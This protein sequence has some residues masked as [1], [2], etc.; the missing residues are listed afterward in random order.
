MGEARGSA[1][2]H[3]GV[4]GSVGESGL[5]GRVSAGKSREAGRRAGKCGGKQASAGE[6]GGGWAPQASTW[7][8]AGLTRGFK[9]SKAPC[10]Y[11]N[12]L[13]RE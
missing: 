6:G 11:Q 4:W 9:G 8:E 3:A 10:R 1:R 12:V 7:H 5:V 2:Q 13:K